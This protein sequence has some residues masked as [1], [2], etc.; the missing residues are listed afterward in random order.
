MEVNNGRTLEKKLAGIEEEIGAASKLI[1]P[2]NSLLKK[3]LLATKQGQLKELMSSIEQAEKTA[4][5][6]K[7]QISNI[8]NGWDINDQAYIASR[9]FIDEI[10]GLAREKGLNLYERDERIYCYPVIVRVLPSDRAIR[11][12]KLIDKRIRPSV[13]VNHLKDIQKRPLRFNASTFIESIYTAYEKIVQIKAKDSLQT[14][15]VIPLFD[16]YELFTMLPHQSKEYSKQE[17]ARDIY[18]LHTSEIQSTKSGLRV[19]FPASTGTKSPGR[20]L[21]LIDEQGTERRYYGICF[22]RE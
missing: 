11:I 13:I 16:I 2:L 8:K 20:L 15:R 18:L 7:Q 6:L 9:A 21:N 10:I 17:F 19:S 14:D 3:C 1:A 12:D 22:S 5:V 4:A